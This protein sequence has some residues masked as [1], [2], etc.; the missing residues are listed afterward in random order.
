VRIGGDFMSGRFFAA[1]FLVAV[2]LVFVCKFKISQRVWLGL[3]VFLLV[4][5]LQLGRSPMWSGKYYHQAPGAK[6]VVRSIADERGYYYDT[7]GLLNAHVGYPMP[8]HRWAHD[9]Q[10]RRGG[11]FGTDVL[12]TIGYFGY[13]A[14]P[15]SHVVDVHALGDPLLARLPVSQ[16]FYDQYSGKNWRIG[17][18]A[19]DVPVGYLQT[20]ESGENKIENSDL[21]EYWDHL[22]VI[23][24]GDLL[25]VERL[26][27]IAKMN[28]GSYD[29]LI[30]KY[31]ESVQ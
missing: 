11:E 8:H 26:V 6:S 5:N 9:G 25:S 7:A 31:L 28:T 3:L 22:A 15:V 29:H 27:E 14:G 20:L 18:F 23:V 10:A 21:A 2:I 13:Y 16:T 4:L 12:H 1:P 24:R 19:R 30:E 17:H